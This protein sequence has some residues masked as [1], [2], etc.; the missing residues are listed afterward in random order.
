[1]STW[2][3]ARLSGEQHQRINDLESQLGVTL[4]AYTD[5]AGKGG[6]AVDFRGVGREEYGAETFTSAAGGGIYNG[7]DAALRALNETYRSGAAPGD[8]RA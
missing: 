7:A 2:H 6:P 4:I 3:L 1:M 8:N 5:D